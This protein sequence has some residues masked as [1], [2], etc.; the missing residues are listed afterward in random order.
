[1]QI[2]S[3]QTCASVS[4]LRAQLANL[5]Q[6]FEEYDLTIDKESIAAIKQLQENPQALGWNWSKAFGGDN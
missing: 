2:S 5:V 6:S 1:M 4:R 3:N